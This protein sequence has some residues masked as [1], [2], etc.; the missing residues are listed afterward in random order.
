MRGRIT[1][2]A[3]REEILALYP[4]YENYSQVSRISGIPLKTVHDIV[5]RFQDQD[6]YTEFRNQQK[7]IMIQEA[8][9]KA[10]EA[11]A[12]ISKDKYRSN[13][14]AVIVFGT[15]VDKMSVLAGENTKWANQQINIGDNRKIEI[16]ITK[17]A[18]SLV[19]RK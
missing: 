4:L 5:R 12:A 1:S 3:K 16:S 10:T 8:H 19:K 18:E 7:K 9:L 6:E 2:P 11:M 14:E 17:D 15:L 13:M